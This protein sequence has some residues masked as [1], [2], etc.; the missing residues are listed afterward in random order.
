M[1]GPLPEAR[2][3]YLVKQ[4]ELALRGRLDSAVRPHGLTV[5]QYT[6]L[7]ELARDPGLSAAELARRSFVSAQTMQELIVRLEQVGLVRRQPAE[8]NKRVL[9]TTL[10]ELGQRKL[11][12]CD[13]EVDE[14]ERDMLA[15]LDGE[16]TEALRQVLR[17][18]TKRVRD[19]A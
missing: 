1:S 12:G 13:H 4:L 6:A 14:I 18:C 9:E 15:D 5:V 10:T 16:A 8:H 7:T 2:T 3:A 19:G 11:H 17:S